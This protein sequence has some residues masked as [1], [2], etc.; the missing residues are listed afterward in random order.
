MDVIQ[1][2]ILHQH[3][4]FPLSYKGAKYNI[5]IEWLI[6]LFTETLNSWKKTCIVRTHMIQG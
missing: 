6:V 2:H 3:N 4:T 5:G 1:C